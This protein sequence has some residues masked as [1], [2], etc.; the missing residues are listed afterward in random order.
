VERKPAGSRDMPVTDDM[1]LGVCEARQSVE[2][3][4]QFSQAGAF[5]RA[6]L[7]IPPAIQDSSTCTRCSH[8]H[9][10]L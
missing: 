9:S 4:R 6:S 7:C 1:A 3:R 10:G 2:R 5:A 8:E